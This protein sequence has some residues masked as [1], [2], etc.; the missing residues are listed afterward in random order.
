MR[1]LS[2]TLFSA[3]LISWGANSAQ[4][5]VT[6]WK[7]CIDRFN[8]IEQLPHI[9]ESVELIGTWG[10]GDSIYWGAVAGKEDAIPFLL[11]KISDSSITRASVPYFGVDYTIG[12]IAYS[13]LGEIISGI[14]TF[15]LVPVEFDEN[16][17]GGCSFWRYLR[18]SHANRIQFSESVKKWY[19][20]H[21]EKLIWVKGGR[22]IN[23]DCWFPHPNGGY[24]ILP[25]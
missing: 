9:C 14:P 6:N 10:C 21:K 13:A 25:D 3:L 16:G 2:I 19:N 20:D 7:E 22:S 11:E 18:E 5:K 24:F 12:E 15:E 8:E 17:C 1:I 4:N 23:C